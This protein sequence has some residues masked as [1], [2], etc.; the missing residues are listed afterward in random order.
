M[1]HLL[2]CLSLLFIQ[3]TIFAQQSVV[4]QDKNETVIIG[5][6][7]SY[8]EDKNG[9][10]TI[11]QINSPEYQA[12]FIIS[13]KPTLNFSPVSDSY[14]WIRLNI[15]NKTTEKD[16]VLELASPFFE[17]AYWYV[18][19]QGSWQ[20]QKD[21][22]A[23][24]EK[25]R[26]MYSRYPAISLNIIPNTMQ[27]IYLKI[28]TSGFACPLQIE[29]TKI[30]NLENRFRDISFGTM[31]SIIFFIALICLYSYFGYKRI[32]YLI[33]SFFTF[34]SFLFLAF[35][36]GYWNTCF[37][38]W[39]T[40][41][42]QIF[43]LMYPVIFLRIA[44]EFPKT[45]KLS[46]IIFIY[47]LLLYIVC[48]IVP[49][50]I[51]N[52]IAQINYLGVSLP[53]SLYLGIIS[54]RKGNKEAG[55]YLL[56][57]LAQ[58]FFGFADLMIM[59]LG[60]VQ[61]L[62]KL[63]HLGLLIEVLI[64]VYALAN[65]TLREQNELR[66]AKDEAQKEMLEQIKENARIV[67]EQNEVLEKNV[68][69]RTI[70]LQYSNEELATT[71]EELYQTQEEI[72]TQRD[73]LKE[74]NNLL[75][76]YT[77]KISKS[78]EAAQIIQQ[79]ILPSKAKMKEL[80]EE[81]FV[82]FCPKD[83]VSGDFWWANEFEGRKYLIV[84]DCTGHGVSGAM[85]TM[86][87][88]SLLDRIIRGLEITEPAEILLK[89]HEEIRAALQQEQ[90]KNN[91]GMDIAI[92]YWHYENDTCLVSFAAAKR[93]LYYCCGGEIEKIMGSRRNVGGMTSSIKSFESKNLSLQKGTC[94]YLCSDGF[95]DQNDVAR[96][97]F[98]EKRLI[99]LLQQ[100]QDLP[101][102]QQKEILETALAK[103]SEG[104]EQRDDILVIGI[105]I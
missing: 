71:N 67:E 51:H 13:D 86:I 58:L 77:N 81:Y 14:Y 104:T 31:Q 32:S 105:R 55:L 35:Y 15:A 33:F 102:E 40:I 92:A 73:L 49:Y 44:I 34:G 94:L 65:Q 76:Q 56:G 25:D 78:I 9:K 20:I 99:S 90:T 80:F 12:K 11:E 43:L 26:P 54:L 69:E 68:T 62:I 91:E 19:N 97:N 96:N 82:L 4:L 59:N 10:L 27:T 64:F 38:K 36:Q 74:K 5:R 103:Y 39:V 50:Y 6:E 24:P 1:K 72:L 22:F 29:S 61:P 46:K 57:I 83:V 18:Q 28:R 70:E 93:P 47:L 41:P 87:G 100:T 37:M 66:K 2:L 45:Y 30:Y 52:L 75:E 85:L 60:I 21:G 8:L 17:F 101:M 42:N 79:A 23:I 98:S 3:I 16:W 7:V 53:F 95:A 48:H 88:S 63:F 84:A 89:L